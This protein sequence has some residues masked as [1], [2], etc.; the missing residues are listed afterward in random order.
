MATDTVQ[1]SLAVGLG[2][3][4]SV[5][6]LVGGE[7]CQNVKLLSAA[8]ASETEVHTGNGTNGNS[9]RVTVASDSTGQTKLAA[10]SAS[11]GT[12]GLNTGTNSVG[13]VGLN[14]GT[15]SIGSTN[16]AVAHDAPFTENPNSILGTI[17]Y[18]QDGTAPGSSVAELDLTRL[19]ADLDGRQYVNTAHP[20]LWSVSA[21]FAAAQTNTTVKAAPGANLSLH[22]TDIAVSNGAVAGN[23]TLLDGSGGTVLYEAYLPVNGQATWNLRTPIRLTANTL[24]AITSTSSTTHAINV[25]GYIAP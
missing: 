2:D 9:L 12:V 7:K 23:V 21:D 10:G 17:A 16:G 25:T 22:V 1:L 20:N 11:V 13:T 6:N 15:N 3:K 14:T 8:D 18:A 19:K 5:N 24:L 4:L